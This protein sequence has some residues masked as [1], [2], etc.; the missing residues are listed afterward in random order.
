MEQAGIPRTRRRL[1]LGH[2]VRSVTD[3]Y[4]RHQVDAFLADDAAKLRAFLG[5]EV[6]R[7]ALRLG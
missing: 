7:V 3:L 1:Y 2:G 5:E 4:E 6:L